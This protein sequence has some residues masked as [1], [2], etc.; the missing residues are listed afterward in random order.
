MLACQGLIYASGTNMVSFTWGGWGLGAGG[1][2]RGS[3]LSASRNQAWSVTESG[4]AFYDAKGHISP[5]LDL[6]SLS[7]TSPGAA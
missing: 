2:G 3:A 7:S 5:P 6:I 1:Q 4:F